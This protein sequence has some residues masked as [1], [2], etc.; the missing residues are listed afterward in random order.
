MR[1]YHDYVLVAFQIYV[2]L[3]QLF[4]YYFLLKNNNDHSLGNISI[5]IITDSIPNKK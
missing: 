1:R 5:E 2:G 4:N 3:K